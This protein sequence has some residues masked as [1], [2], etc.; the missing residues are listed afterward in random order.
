MKKYAFA[1]LIFGIS[2]AAFADGDF[3][4]TGTMK[5]D[6]GSE[7]AAMLHIGCSSDRDGGALVIEIT[8][9]DANT[10]KDFDYDDFEGPDAHAGALSHLEWITAAGKTSITA[11]AAGSYI[12]EP[13][14]AFQFGIDVLS[15]RHSSGATLMASVKNDPGKLTWTQS[16]YDKSKRKLVATFDMDAS[17]AE[18]IRETTSACLPK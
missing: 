12:P 6:A 18:R 11:T 7:R 9:P 3:S 10:K 16:S 1:I 8:I 4:K 5:I 13:P 17:E 15:H 2:S 14:E